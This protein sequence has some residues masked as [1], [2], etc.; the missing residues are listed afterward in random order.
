MFIDPIVIAGDGACADVAP[1]TD[2]SVTQVG[3]VIGLTALTKVGVFRL[4]KVANPGCFIENR[5][6]SQSGIGAQATTGTNSGAL[7]VA[8]RLYIRIGTHLD[9]AQHTIGPDPHPISQYD[10]TLENGIDVY[11]YVLPA[12]QFTPNIDTL[13]VLN[14]HPRSQQTFCDP[15]LVNALKALQL[16]AI[17]NALRFDNILGLYDVNRE[18][19]VS[20][21][22]QHIG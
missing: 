7:N 15:L 9:I 13:A 3:Q 21:Q 2:L 11:Q 18:T 20:C 16:D 4:D 10:S 12:A 8:K 1:R 19:F 22:S 14:S 6:R 17:I 5:P